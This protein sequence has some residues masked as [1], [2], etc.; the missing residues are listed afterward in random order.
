[1]IQKIHSRKRGGHRYEVRGR[2][3]GKYGKQVRRRFRT[4]KEAQAFELEMQTREARRK[5]GLPPEREAI[6]YGDL[7]QKFLAQYDARSK[8]WKGEM[9]L[10]SEKRFASALVR[11][12]L[13]DHISTWLSELPLS[14]KTKKHILDSMRQVLT[15]GVEWGYLAKNPARPSAVRGP[16]QVEP[17]VRPFRS[18]AEVEALAACAGSYGPL[19]LF[20]SATGLRPEEW[21]AL[22]WEDI[23]MQGRSLSV[24]KVCVDGV[25]YRDQGK[26]ETAF[27][28]V[29]L[30][31]IA[32]EALA[33]M[34][35]P[36]RGECLVFTAPR[37]G[38]INLNNWRR[39]QWKKA[40]DASGL[41]PR[42][43]YQM[44][45][46]YAT[47]ALSAGA[48][49]YWVSGQMG[50]KDIRVTLKHYAR[51]QRQPAVSERNLRF[52]DD[53]AIPSG[54]GASEVRH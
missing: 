11:D 41:E 10:Y 14:Q 43:L 7:V 5:N 23:D 44:R 45:H 34:P 4:M 15:T 22:H 24:N 19:I 52:L 30:Q 33:A 3:G 36:I 39:R 31:Q 9:L 32:L 20:A 29:T 26:S 6:S 35:R 48:D 18:W 21:I 53:F 50:H 13:P 38:L 1:M 25:V 37:G 2:D 16:K 40:V 8:A 27:R 12:L 28:T 47:L 49:I 42:P 17:N 46:T 54:E 51:F